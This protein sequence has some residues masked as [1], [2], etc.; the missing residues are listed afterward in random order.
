MEIAR[1]MQ[2]S[3]QGMRVE[4]LREEYESLPSREYFR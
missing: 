3:E 1:Q 4:L 2:S